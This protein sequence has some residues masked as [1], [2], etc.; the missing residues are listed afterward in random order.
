MT[1][2]EREDLALSLHA[3]AMPIAG[4]SA[5]PGDAHRIG[6][7]Q[8]VVMMLSNFSI[9]IAYILPIV[10]SL[11]LRV[12]ELAPGRPEIL[13]YI[14]GSAQ[15]IY[16][17]ASPLIGVWSDRLQT[18]F[19]RRRPFLV[20]GLLVG[21]SGLVIVAF[22]WTIE[23]VGAG[24]IVALFGFATA[25]AATNAQLADWLTDNQRGKVSGLLGLSGQLGPMAGLGLLTILTRDTV[26]IVLIP[27]LIAIALSVPFLS[28]MTD[29]D[30]RGLQISKFDWTRIAQSYV[31]DPRRYPDFA[32]NWLGRT[33]FFFGLYFNTTFLTFFYASRLSKDVSEVGGVASI[34]GLAGIGAASVGA[35]S[36]GILSDVFGRRKV[37]VL[38]AAMI[39]AAGALV[40]AFAYTFSAL[41]VGGILMQIS[42]A[43]FAAVDQAIVLSTMPDR[44]GSARYLAIAA[45]SQKI[46]SALAPILGA[47]IFNDSLRSAQ[48]YTALYLTGGACALI[49]GLIIAFTVK[50]VR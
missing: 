45:F 33:V 48:E 4:T 40:D 7:M 28:I 49:G 6:R 38:I 2:A 44:Q 42:I 3:G 22:S 30:S 46:P 23:S 26:T 41:L 50:G 32:W 37:F 14:T 1:V 11:A 15:F 34:I 27:G 35:L 9:S 31:V 29:P 39:F 25:S 8:V 10:Y 20:G 19:G 24:W 36:S 17:L 16:I 13:G 21:T 43:A 12:N 47:I 5:S 18:R